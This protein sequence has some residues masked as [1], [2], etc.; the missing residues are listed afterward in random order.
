VVA[1]PAPAPHAVPASLQ[2]IALEPALTAASVAGG[3]RTI[4]STEQRSTKPFEA[5]GVTW[6]P[7]PAVGEVAVTART[8]TSGRWTEWTPLDQEQEMTK[9]NGALDNPVGARAGT[10]PAWVGDSDGVQVRISVHSGKAPQDVK[11]TLIDPGSSEAD[12]ASAATLGGSMAT[13]ATTQP[14]IRSRASGAPTS[15]SAAGPRSPARFRPWRSTT[16]RAA[17]TTPRPT[18]R[19]SS[20]VSTPTT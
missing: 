2:E 9:G 6:A 7:D 5:Y 18:C 4:V 20:A 12:A 8:R 16:P 11:L 1:K 19:G 10:E 14:V 3:P 15:R 17:T 13:A